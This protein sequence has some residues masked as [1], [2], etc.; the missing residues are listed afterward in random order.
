MV[1]TCKLHHILTYKD[2]NG[3]KCIELCSK[4]NLKVNRIELKETQGI[5]QINV[6][7]DLMS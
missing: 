3:E 2:L 4:S 5:W 7:L 6:I 1:T